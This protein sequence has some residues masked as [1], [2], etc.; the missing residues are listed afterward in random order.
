MERDKDPLSDEEKRH[1]DLWFDRMEKNM[2]ARFAG[3]MRTISIAWAIAVG[4][5]F[6]LSTPDLIRQLSTDDALR[7]S[8]VASA[9]GVYDRATVTMQ[10]AS[11]YED[12]SEQALQQLE[13]SHPDLEALIEE[14]SGVGEEN[15]DVL[16]EL[17]LVL[18][19]H[20]QQAELLAEYQGLLDG[21]TREARDAALDDAEA[22]IG[23]LSNFDIRPW[24]HGWRFYV[25]NG[26]PRVGNIAGVL[27]TV[28]F[29]SFGAPFW[30][31]RIGEILKL[32]DLLSP[33]PSPPR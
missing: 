9:E 22:A 2:A 12:V 26:L 14:V 8:L 1:V 20:P 3:L 32:R 30:H 11:R 10:A 21:L 15:A 28:I 19:D 18:G 29:L 33:R 16:G 13:T 23:Q 7:A 17:E 4:A 24:P 25:G 27:I 6:Q 31:S 5:W